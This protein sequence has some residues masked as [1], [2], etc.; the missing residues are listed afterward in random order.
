MPET[1]ISGLRIVVTRP[2]RQSA[3]LVNELQTAGAIPVLFPVMRIEP[4]ADVPG[5]DDSLRSLEQYRW[6]VFTSANGVEVIWDRMAALGVPPET[7]RAP[8]VAAIGPATADALRDRG[9]NPAFVPEAFVGEY[10]GDGLPDVRGGRV[11]LARAA[12][13]RPALPDILA[14]RGAQ[15]DEFAIY[16]A[17][18][19][20]PS[21][22]SYAQLRLGVDVLTFTSPS[23]VHH[24]LSALEG[25]GFDP[26][27]LPGE[28][29]VACIG[30][31]TA[32]AAAG[33]GLAP[34]VIAHTFTT[35]GLIQALAG[36]FAGREAG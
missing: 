16:R 4:L 26:R 33:A 30:P 9:V 21:S 24:F 14:R 13:S 1:A 8:Q 2:L 31:V 10:L 11:L 6:L 25:S 7:V 23:T 5:L 35:D 15:V 3:G 29:I 28:P 19:T 20:R 34:Q 22:Q 27:H 18:A 12:D 36:H 17:V 32:E